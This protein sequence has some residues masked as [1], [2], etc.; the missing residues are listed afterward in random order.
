[1][2]HL[3]ER[4]RILQVKNTEWILML[5]FPVL[6]VMFQI[7]MV[8]SYEGRGSSAGYLTVSFAIVAVNIV[9]FG[10]L[11]HIS[12]QEKKW[13]QVRLLQENN[14]V[15]MQAYHEMNVDYQE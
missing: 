7:I 3:R 14:R 6:S 12:E 1:M 8:L 11:G 2:A 15:R 4:V 13:N 5:C 9:M 10:W